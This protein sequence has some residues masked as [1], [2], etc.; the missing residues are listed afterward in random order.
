[1]YFADLSSLLYQK[2]PNFKSLPK[3]TAFLGGNLV[4]EVP[5]RKFVRKFVREKKA[6]VTSV[7]KTN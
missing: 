5:K 3:K 2:S 6:P 4:K 1:L 7:T